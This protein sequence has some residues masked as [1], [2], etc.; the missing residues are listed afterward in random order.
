METKNQLRTDNE[1][2]PNNSGSSGILSVIKLFLQLIS[3][4]RYLIPFLLVALAVP[5]ILIVYSV[6]IPVS[7]FQAVPWSGA[8][9][10]SVHHEVKPDRAQKEKLAAFIEL[11]KESIFLHNKLHLAK[12][13]SIYLVLDMKDSTINLEIKGVTV[14]KNKIMESRMSKRFHLIDHENLVPWLTKPFTLEK[15]L[16]TIPKA[17]IVVKQAPKDTVEAALMATKPEPPQ[18]TAV[19]FTFYFDRNLVIE[20]DQ[21]DPP[22]EEDY[23]QVKAY[24]KQRKEE[25]YLSLWQKMNLVRHADQKMK[26]RLVV[27]EEDARSIYRAVPMNTHLIL[28][29]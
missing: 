18:T 15:A 29:W 12:Q 17:P 22:D 13:D 6:V 14:R 20:I 26:I 27:S 21:N 9:P 11:E 10:D 7:R 8:T 28:R 23:E 1:S 5:L 24:R 19:F 25:N 2:K 16:A 3:K 4:P